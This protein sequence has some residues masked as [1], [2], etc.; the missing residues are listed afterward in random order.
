MGGRGFTSS[1][2][3]K[4]SSRQKDKERREKGTA[5]RKATAGGSGESFT[6]VK[7]QTPKLNDADAKF[8]T[9]TS[10][11]HGKTLSTDQ[12]N[13]LKVYSDKDYRAINENL[14]KGKISGY[15]KAQADRIESAIRLA[16]ALKEGVVMYRGATTSQF[17]KLGKA[18]LTKGA[19]LDLPAFTSMSLSRTVAK[20]FVGDNGAFL[21]K[22]QIPKGTRI[23][24]L[25]N[26]GRSANPSEYEGILNKGSSV[27]VVNVRRNRKIKTSLGEEYKVNMVTIRVI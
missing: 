9:E 19:E 12:R 14:S 2:P 6:K 27:K 7:Q 16:P 17:G 13:A 25:G 21:I 3:E 4:F 23:G 8:I 1:R 5:R 20:D 26:G 24:Y 10:D 22:V 11:W 18:L 15:Y